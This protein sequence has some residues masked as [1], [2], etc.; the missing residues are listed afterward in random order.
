MK[1]E[2]E[3]RSDIVE[4]GRRVYAKGYVAANDGNISIRLSDDE[5]LVT[6]TGMSKGFL[7]TDQ[8]IKVAM[9]GEQIEGYLR[10]SSE[11]PFHLKVYELRDD[12]KAIAHA[13]PPISTA[14]A[15]A[16]I[17][18]DEMILPEMI[19]SLGCIPIAKYGT[20]GTEE[21]VE[22]IS[23]IIPTC[24]AI[25]LANHGALT[26][27]TDVYSAY[28]KM[29]TMEHYAHINWI[30]RTLGNINPLG[31]EELQKLLQLREQLGVKSNLCDR[32]ST[33]LE[34]QTGD[35]GLG[36]NMSEEE[37]IELITRVTANVIRGL[38]EN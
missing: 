7:S 1:T 6:P 38:G 15:V 33:L 24:D 29:E 13:H 17:P 12:V 4:I 18:L 22:S 28:Y 30:A 25:L 20:P 27:G 32:C 19:I 14:F 9:S 16:G 5:V 35:N 2:K 10:P 26:V 31:E 34:L 11:L 36:V 21:L 3:Y 8:L 23:E 37:L